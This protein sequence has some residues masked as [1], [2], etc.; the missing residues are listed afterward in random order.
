MAIDNHRRL[1]LACKVIDI[2]AI[3]RI[4]IDMTE[5]KPVR[6]ALFNAFVGELMA[7]C[8]AMETHQANLMM[9]KKLKIYDREAEV[10]E[11]IC[12]VR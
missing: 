10:L 1:Q 4:S 2:R 9:M 3:N 5:S 6:Y 12:H 7:D 8:M 11:K